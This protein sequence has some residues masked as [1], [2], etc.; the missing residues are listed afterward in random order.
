[1]QTNNIL[2]DTHVWIWLMGG[3]QCLSSSAQEIIEKAH[4]AG[5]VFVSAISCWEIA[6]LEQKK[7]VVLNKPCLDWIKTSLHYGIQLLPITPEISVESCHLPDYFAGDPADRIIIAT[8]R[9]ESLLLVTRDERI[10]KYADQQMVL[11]VNA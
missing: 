11:A 9:I 10:L 4:Q 8:A 7:R 1:M 6:M 5:G 2:L 3:D